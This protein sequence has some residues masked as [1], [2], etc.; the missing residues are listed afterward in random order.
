MLIYVLAYGG[1]EAVT[2]DDVHARDILIP[3][4]VTG[5]VAVVGFIF[6]GLALGSQCL[7]AIELNTRRSTELMERMTRSPASPVNEDRKKQQS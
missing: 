7:L 3:L 4:F 5:R 6:V 2:K 1:Y